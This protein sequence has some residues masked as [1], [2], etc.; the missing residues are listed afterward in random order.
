MTFP[1]IYKILRFF[2]IVLFIAGFVLGLFVFFRYQVTPIDL[3]RVVTKNTQNLKQI[4]N[5]INI[6]L[7]G[8]GGG[9]H[10]GGNLTDTILV[11]SV[12]LKTNKDTMISLPRDIY[13]P[14][15][16]NRINEAYRI[17]EE[18]NPGS[19]LLLA[20]ASIEEVIGIPIHHAILIDFSGF[21]KL[22]DTIGGVD[23]NVAESFTDNNYPIDGRENDLCDGDVEFSCRY[24]S[25][26]FAEGSEH[27]D[28]TR[29]L[30]YVRSRHAQGDTGNDFSRGKRQQAVLLALKNKLLT[31]DIL[32]S[33][34]KILE[35]EAVVKTVTM[36]DL[37]YGEE[38]LLARI[39]LGSERKLRQIALTYEDKEKQQKGLLIHPPLW[40]YDEKWVLIPKHDDFSQIHAYIKCKFEEENSCDRY[41]E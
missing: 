17:G 39:V 29:A 35:L 22:I 1:G 24:E 6:A 7:L 27:M 40:Q 34:K 16:K 25:I 31:S 14:S 10:E 28:G 4:N 20:K 8:I 9:T 11:M 38:L 26:T 32:I 5:R 3:L 33:S 41:I 37:S 13:L 18:K 21:V 12:D 30:K 2:L 19:G 23:V 36:T 15:L